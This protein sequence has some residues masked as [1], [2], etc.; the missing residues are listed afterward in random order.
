MQTQTATRQLRELVAE[1][2]SG[3][4]QLPQFQRDYVWR[5]RKIRNLLDSLWR[6]YPI[7]GFY[8]WRP[9]GGALDP[10]PKAFGKFKIEGQFVGYLIDG[11]QRLTSLEA[12]FGLYS[13]EDKRGDEL[14]CYLD[15]SANEADR[16]RDTRLFVSYGGNQWVAWRVDQG[17][18]TLIPLRQL[19]HGQDPDLRRK[20]EDALRTKGINGKKLEAALAR[21]DAACRMLD[22]PVPC[23]TVTNITDADA[24]KVFDRLNKG[25]TQ[26]RQGD[27]KAAELARGAAV[28][29]LKRMREF[30]AG[31]RPQRLGFGFSFAFR[32]LVVF[33]RGSAQFATLKA[34]WMEAPGPDGRSLAQSWRATER[35]LTEALEFLDLKMGWSRRILLPSANAAIVLGSALD[36]ADFHFSQEEEVLLRRWLCLTALRGVFQGSVETTINRSLRAIKDG[37]RSPAKALLEALRRNERRAID[38]DELLQPAHLW[39]PATQV[40]HSWLVN[41]RA[42][43][44]LE[45]DKTIDTLA[46]QGDSMPGGDLTVHHTFPRKMLADTMDDSESDAANRPANLALISRASNSEIGDKRPDEVLSMLTPA[47]RKLAKV[48]FF[49]NDAGD[50]LEADHYEEYCEWRAKRLAE[51]MNE[52]LGMR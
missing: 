5:P 51:A 9:S 17:D 16:R 2:A 37:R 22:Q 50:L 28:Q 7:G 48:Q 42:R 25:G 44:W 26:L 39:G 29:V 21:F 43:D 12:A 15:L 40:M 33:H 10:K 24:V 4:I 20:T 47:Q 31:E 52:Y 23:T 1:F 36:R 8:L 19:F 13:G 11:Q 18:P 34:D 45:T 6:G 41:A 14:R 49:G 3:Q 27:V 38:A 32:A 46:R 30:V 35:A